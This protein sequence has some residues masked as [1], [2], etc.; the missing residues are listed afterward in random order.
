MLASIPEF[1]EV[2]FSHL[3]SAGTNPESVEPVRK[4]R[5]TLLWLALLLSLLL[6]LS[7][8][9][10]Q[11]GEKQ[12]HSQLAPTPTL[13]INLRQLP[14]KTQD[15]APEIITPGVIEIPPVS[16]VE[17]EVVASSVIAEKVVKVEKPLTAKP[18]TR[19]VIEPLSAQELKEVVE[20]HN[21]QSASQSAAAIA[22]NV[23]HPGLRARLSAEANKPTLMRVEDSGLQTFTDPAGATVVKLPGGS[24]MSSPA[25]T[26][27]G[28]PK[29]WYFTACGGQSES[30]KML[31]RVN[32][33]V[34]GKLRFD[35]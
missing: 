29:N 23:F 24:C 6:H 26:K 13:H 20:S 18:A 2:D 14:A 12:F 4:Q 11:F 33:D 34:K 25:N 3:S 17:P 9:L 16:N 10:F 7:L 21:A 32:S 1:R 35:E 8:L 30:E 22:E 28:A 27:I 15:I 31:E 5:S 19:L